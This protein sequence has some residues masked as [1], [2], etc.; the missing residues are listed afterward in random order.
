MPPMRWWAPVLTRRPRWGRANQL[1][2]LWL[3]VLLSPKLRLEIHTRQYQ[4]QRVVVFEVHPAFD[5][6]VEFRGAY[7]RNGTS[8]AC[9][10]TRTKS[11][12]LDAPWTGAHRCVNRPRWQT[13]P[14]GHC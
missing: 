7:V 5:R 10:V 9:Q 8:K 2:L 14:T 1:L 4:G 13:G 6:P 3:A 12:L 11:A